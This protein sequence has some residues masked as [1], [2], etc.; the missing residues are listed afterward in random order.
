MR[1]IGE[2][3]QT[4][5]GIIYWNYLFLFLGFGFWFWFFFFCNR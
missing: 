5:Q 4:I 3:D 1:D 2:T